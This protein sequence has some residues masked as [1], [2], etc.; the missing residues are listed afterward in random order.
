M[1]IR[2][3]RSP[4]RRPPRGDRGAAVAEF[5]LVAVLLV[6]LFLVVLQVGVYLHERNVMAASAQAGAR[7]AANA[8][9]DSASGAA[10]TRQLI[11]ES[12][13]ADAAAGL[14]CTSGEETGTGG[15]VVVVV[16][17]TGSIP[18]VV[19]ALGRLIPVTVT[20][21]AIKEGQP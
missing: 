6:A 20:G 18:S 9:V 13:S 17:C 19:T 16:R 2:V 4:R 12:L 8:N 15:L 7:Y 11:T 3:R 10:R 14:R 1:S 21:R 5:S